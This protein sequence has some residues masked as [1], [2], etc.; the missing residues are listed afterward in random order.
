MR[1]MLDTDSCIYLLKGSSPELSARVS[2]C[3]PGELVLSAV[4]YAELRYGAERSQARERNLERIEQLCS[5]AAVL[6]FDEAAARRA[7]EVRATLA[8]KGTPIGPMDTLIAAHALET[9]VTLVTNNVR[10]FRRVR[11]LSVENWTAP[12]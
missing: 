11:G 10:E 6:P 3:D 7:G 2:L 1:F 5:E 9:E 8:R 12:A 4:T